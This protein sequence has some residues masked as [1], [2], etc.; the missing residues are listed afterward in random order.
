MLSHSFQAKRRQI[1]VSVRIPPVWIRRARGRYS[2]DNF[3]HPPRRLQGYSKSLSASSTSRRSDYSPNFRSVSYRFP[4][5]VQSALPR[6]AVPVWR[7]LPPVRYGY[8]RQSPAEAQI[9]FDSFAPIPIVPE[10]MASQRHTRAHPLFHSSS[11]AR[12]SIHGCT[13]QSAFA[14]PHL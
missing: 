14:P 13:R 2:A 5:R 1:L 8:L 4:K 9:P 6:Y 12:V 11:L 7:N 10:L 3:R